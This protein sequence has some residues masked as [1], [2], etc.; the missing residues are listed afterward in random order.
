[1]AATAGAQQQPC[2]IP[3]NHI[4]DFKS[5]LPSAQPDS[6]RIPSTHV[7]QLIGQQG[8]PYTDTSLGG[9]KGLFDF[10]GYVPLNGSSR[11]GTVALNHEGGNQVTGG[12]SLIDIELDSATKLWQITNKMPVDF[13]GIAGTG[14]NC[15]GGIT[16]W[17]TSITSEETLPSGDANGDGYQDIGWNV[18]ID[19]VTRKIKDYNND[20]IPDKLWKMGR[21][22]H[23]NVVVSNDSIT[24][25]EANDENPGYIFKFVAT[26]KGDLSDG[27][28]YVLRL[29]GGID[30]STTGSWRKVPN[31]TPTECNNVRAAAT[32]LGATNFNSLEDVEISPVDGMI[33]FV[34]KASSRVYRFQDFGNTVNNFGVFAGNPSQNYLI[35]YE[36]GGTAYEQWRDGN[37]NLTF[38]NLG[39]LYV[40]QDG[41][42]NHIWMITPCHTQQNPDVRLFAVTPAGCE[43]TGMTFSPDFRY[44]FVSMQHPSSSN[45]VVQVDAAG[46]NVV[47][48]KESAIVIA[49]KGYLGNTDTTVNPL[50]VGAVS[51]PKS[52][53][54]V[55]VY[56]NPTSSDVSVSINSEKPTT[57]YIKVYSMTGIAVLNR[58]VALAKGSTTVKLNTATVAAGTYNVIITTSESQVSTRIIRQ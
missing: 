44:M 50:N 35:E 41:G 52:L 11:K 9:L 58:E 15:S 56:P 34:S 29:D 8:D 23:E 55:Q 12:V 3:L 54:V 25:Y 22:S 53:E 57:A 39:N 37:D 45:A 28:L 19:P 27:D 4:S 1:M 51:A 16:P 33:Y 18:E 10:T 7:F 21:M 36:G 43:P 42:R 49:H 48:N 20:T 38:D 46:N 13:S 2:N 32:S 40:I 14:R 30:V 31:S 5:V 17:G 24:V 26:T 47:F 6:L